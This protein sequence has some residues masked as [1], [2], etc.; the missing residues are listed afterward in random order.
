METYPIFQKESINI[1]INDETHKNFDK[2]LNWTNALVQNIQFNSPERQEVPLTF[3]PIAKNIRT[4]AS[5]MVKNIL[6]NKSSYID[7]IARIGEPNYWTN[8]LKRGD[9]YPW[10]WARNRISGNYKNIDGWRYY[11]SSFTENHRRIY[12]GK[13]DMVKPPEQLKLFFIH[14]SCI[15]YTFQLNEKYIA[16]MET[17][18]T[19]MGW[20]DDAKILAVQIRRGDTSTTDGKKTDRE[21]YTLDEYIKKIDQMI[22][23]NNYEYIYIS[24]DSDDEIENIKIARPNWKILSLVIDRKQFFRMSDDAPPSVYGYTGK[25]IEI[26]ESCRLNPG[27]IPFIVDSGLADLYFISKCQGYIST[28]SVSEFSRCGWYLQLATQQ[29]M[30]PYINMNIEILDMDKRDKLLLL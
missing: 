6:S 21:Y 17:Q 19:L 28:I 3:Y 14:L 2:Y 22:L 25:G 20:N 27:A 15:K 11:F 13:E 7:N 18:K 30:T 24:T 4:P 1:D 23:A 26:E 10:L 8:D 12:L 29:K 9:W 5:Y 16:Y